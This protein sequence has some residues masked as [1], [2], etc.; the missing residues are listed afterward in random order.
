MP[1]GLT[2]A[3]ATF[4][5]CMNHIFN[6]QLRIFLLVFFDDLLISNRTWED[7]MR[8][9]DEILG[10]MGE[11]SLYVKASK[12]EFGMRNIIYLGHVISVQGVQV[13]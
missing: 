12:C 7:H 10:F 6:K 1:F 2:N 13:H 11:K 3:H 4:Q 9:L 5:S 8:H